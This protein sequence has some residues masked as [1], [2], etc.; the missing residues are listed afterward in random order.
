MMRLKGKSDELKR[1]LYNLDNGM[2]ASEII[3]A[4][5][6]GQT[7]TV[8]ITIPEGYNNRQIGDLLTE[9]GFF[10]SR[11][12]FLP[13]AENPALLT[14]FQIPAKTTEGYLFPETYYIP[15]GYPKKAIISMMVKQFFKKTAKI[16]NFPENPRARHQKVIL[17][18]IVEREAKLKE[19]RAMIAGVFAN[20]LSIGQPLES[21]AT[22]QYL[23]EKPRKRIY[24]Q[25]LE[26]ESPYN[27]YKHKGMPPGPIASPGYEALNAAVNPEA[28]EYKYFVVRGDGSHVFSKTFREHNRA[29]NEYLTRR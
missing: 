17:A 10:T 24:Y 28:T 9:K 5:T 26:I 3:D 13:H 16:K 4:I 20:R 19:E 23:F 29:K 11:K 22:I 18:S 25:D 7:K 21:C 2:S 8:K 6:S 15:V 27:T 12:E 14:R 1:G